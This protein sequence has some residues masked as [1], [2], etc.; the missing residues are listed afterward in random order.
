MTKKI[1]VSLPMRG[2]EQYEIVKDMERLF[3]LASAFLG[4]ECELINSLEPVKPEEL[5]SDDIVD[6]AP[7]YLGASIKL[8]SQ[9]DLVI[10]DKD[11]TQA[12]GCRIEKQV[13]D[14]YRIKH[15]VEPEL[16]GTF[17]ASL[18]YNIETES[19]Y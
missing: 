19:N 5:Q 17:K 11:W 1:F 6:V 3:K 9:A 12:E 18:S 8:L 10:F 14:T 13:C 2:K 16:L 4:E 15:I 7:L